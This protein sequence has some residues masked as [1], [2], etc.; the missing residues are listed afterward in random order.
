MTGFTMTIGG[1]SAE[2]HGTFDVIN[3][4]TGEV[5]EQA[6]DASREQLDQA[7]A[8][9]QAA[10]PEWR[11]DEEARRKALLAAADL[12]FARSEEIGRILTLEQGKPLRDA[13]REVVGAG[14]WLKYYAGLETPREIIQDD[15]AAF[16]EVVRRPMGVVAAITPWNYPLLLAT[17]KLAPALLAGNTVVLKPSPY[18]PLSSLKLGEVL[19]EVLPPGV[20]NVVTGGN[21]L[22]AWMTSHDVPRKISFTGS[23]ATGKRVAA[24]AAPDLKRVTL[25]LGGNDPA[26]LLD[27]AD[28]AVVADKLFGAAFQNNG[29]VCSAIKRVYVPESLYADVVDALA[30]KARS[31]KVGNGLAEDVQYGPINNKP[32]YDRVSE[33]VAEAL[34]KGARA[35]AGGKPIDGPGYFFEPTILADLADGS[36]IVDEEQFGP[37]LP[38]VKYTDLDEAVARANGTHFGLSGSVWGADADRASE[39]ASRLECGTAWVNTHLALGP[40]QPFGGFKWSG[41]GVEN[42]PWG[43]YGFTELQVIHRSRH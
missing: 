19:R 38:I 3:P 33:L 22:G 14:V 6:P 16:V 8:A 39:V 35:A 36:R 4:A 13:T 7:M 29:Q 32:Q 18:T 9:A 42:G 17:W 41:V 26:I 27:D 2:A 25:E 5:A 43:L 12:M 20:F 37:A 11:R 23:V 21:E 30:A 1:R 10:F 34:A 15:D 24:A 28:P 31:V 40:H